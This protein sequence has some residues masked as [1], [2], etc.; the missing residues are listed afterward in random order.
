MSPYAGIDDL[1]EYYKYKQTKTQGLHLG[2]Y[3]SDYLETMN[4]GLEKISKKYE[5]FH[6]D[7]FQNYLYTNLDFLILLNDEIEMTIF[8]DIKVPH[9]LS[10]KYI[11]VN[12]LEDLNNM[13]MD[14]YLLGRIFKPYNENIIIYTGSSHTN[15]YELFLKNEGFIETSSSTNSDKYNFLCVNIENLDY[16]LF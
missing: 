6:I 8:K 5:N 9:F 10:N 14:I 12:V 7:N 11:F 15:L 1:N 13:F 16:P 3:N 4:E 2:N